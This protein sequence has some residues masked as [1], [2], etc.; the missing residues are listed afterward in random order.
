MSEPPTLIGSRSST[1]IDLLCFQLG[2]A[3]FA[4][5]LASVQEVIDAI[6]LE[7]V[8]DNPLHHLLRLRDGLL[9]VHSLETLLSASVTCREPIALVLARGAHRVAV[10]V[11]TAVAALAIDGDGVRP[12][13]EFLTR[14]R[15][16]IGAMCVGG[17]WCAVLDTDALL[18]ALLAV[19][20]SE[21]GTGVRHAA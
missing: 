11:D 15:V 6:A 2:A 21:P 18:D 9:P 17:G 8:S 5:P 13:P 1:P 20:P 10:L 16:V 3:G 4:L 12:L 19:C 7:H 14:D